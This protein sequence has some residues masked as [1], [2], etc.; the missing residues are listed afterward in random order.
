MRNVQNQRWNSAHPSSRNKSLGGLQEIG[1][2]INLL[3]HH[4]KPY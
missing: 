2:R 3:F 4:G 1:D